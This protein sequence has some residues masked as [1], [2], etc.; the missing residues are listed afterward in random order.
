MEKEEGKEDDV[1]IFPYPLWYAV[2]FQAP[3]EFNA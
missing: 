1:E 3:P 2:S